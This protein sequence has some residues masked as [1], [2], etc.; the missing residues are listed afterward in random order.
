MQA[1][2]ARC[3][4]ILSSNQLNMHDAQQF[5]LN[6]RYRI[7]SRLVFPQMSNQWA[8]VLPIH[9]SGETPCH[10]VRDM[11]MSQGLK[12]EGAMARKQTLTGT[13]MNLAKVFNLIP[14]FVAKWF[15]TRLGLSEH[16]LILW[17]LS[18]RRMTR[19]PSIKGFWLNSLESTTSLPEE[20]S[21]SVLDYDLSIVCMSI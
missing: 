2:A 15:L 3:T 7:A 20:D 10:G 13:S 5:S 14:R 8:Q 18:L 12:L 4:Q 19:L 11:T 21:W 16:F 1:R 6:L 17:S 9:I